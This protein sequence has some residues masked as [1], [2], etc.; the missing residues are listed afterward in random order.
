MFVL[1][2]IASI[3]AILGW[4]AALFRVF[5]LIFVFWYSCKFIRLVQRN[6]RLVPR[7]R[8]L[9]NMIYVQK[10]NK[11]ANQFLVISGSVAAALRKKQITIDQI[12]D[13]V[14]LR[15]IEVGVDID[16]KP[17]KIMLYADS[18]IKYLDGYRK[19]N[20]LTMLCWGIFSLIIFNVVPPAI[21]INKA[22]N[23]P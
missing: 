13:E 4:I 8:V 6:F 17:I 1:R 2:L 3:F 23:Q 19:I 12:N 21:Y 5:E 14:A 22:F 10:L 15:N 18:F 11:N 16:I 20:R 9:S 7:D